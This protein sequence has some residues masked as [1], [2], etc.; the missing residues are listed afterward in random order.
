MKDS[1]DATVNI[2]DNDD[3]QKGKLETKPDLRQHNYCC[4]CIVIYRDPFTGHI[5]CFLETFIHSQ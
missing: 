4:K 2:E 1:Q 5:N 3:L